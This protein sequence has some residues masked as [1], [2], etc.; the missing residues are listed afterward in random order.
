MFDLHMTRY[1]WL[2]HNK[3]CLTCTWQNMFDLC[4]LGWNKND[5]KKNSS[6]NW[7]SDMI[8]SKLNSSSVLKVFIIDVQQAI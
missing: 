6:K 4:T 7:R 8:F 3:I 1:G 2:A 5:K